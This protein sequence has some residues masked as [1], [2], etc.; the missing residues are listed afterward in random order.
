MKQNIKK[1]LRV[2]SEN[3][4]KETEE[5]RD[6]D[7][8]YEKIV[9]LLQD[10]IINHSAVIRTMAHDPW[11]NSSDDTNR[12][13]FKKKVDRAKNDEGSEYRFNEEDLAAIKK[14][15]TTASTSI[16][17]SLEGTDSN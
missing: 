12:S 9:N 10:P 15:L 7:V 2:L 5:K 8:S 16:M 11:N 3:T 13:L 4:D 6:T 17:S 1:Q 14:T